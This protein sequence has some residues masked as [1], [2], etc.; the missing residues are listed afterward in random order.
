MCA[1][2]SPEAFSDTLCKEE[3]EEA[4]FEMPAFDALVDYY[5]CIDFVTQREK[6]TWVPNLANGWAGEVLGEYVTLEELWLRKN[7]AEWGEEEKVEASPL[8]EQSGRRTEIPVSGSFWY[9]E[10]RTLRSLISSLWIFM[11]P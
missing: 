7:Y 4:R 9:T 2:S 10:T 11:K 6:I 1:L 8:Q 5:G 3:T